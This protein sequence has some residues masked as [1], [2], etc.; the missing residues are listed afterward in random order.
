MNHR[1]TKASMLTFSALVAAAYVAIMYVTQGFAFGPVQMRIATALYA[2]P[3]LFPFLVVPL[4][5]ANMLSNMLMGGLGMFDIVGGFAVGL[6]TAGTPALFR[7]LNLPTWTVILP[8]I[9]GPALIVPLWLSRLFAVP[10]WLAYLTGVP[11]YWL[12]VISLALG[13]IVP[14][15]LG[16]ILV[17][18]ISK[19]KE[20]NHE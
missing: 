20:I 9:L 17:K 11:P 13:Q 7:R 16:Y 6:V 10:E 12:F 18:A 8:V 15:I 19:R 4:A 14:S 3:Y 2:L 1:F 5:L